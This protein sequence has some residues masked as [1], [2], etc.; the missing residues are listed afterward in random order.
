MAEKVYCKDCKFMEVKK[1]RFVQDVHKC[2]HPKNARYEDSYFQRLTV[3]W[4]P[5]SVCNSDNSCPLY[6]AKKHIRQ[7]GG[8]DGVHGQAI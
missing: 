3:T 7:L 4:V 2:H 5:P 1:R 8:R 6:E